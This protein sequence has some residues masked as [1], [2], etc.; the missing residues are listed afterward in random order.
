MGIASISN[1]SIEASFGLPFG[2]YSLKIKSKGNSTNLE[3]KEI[4]DKSEQILKNELDDEFVNSLTIPL[5]YQIIEFENKKLDSSIYEI[6]GKL[7][8]KSFVKTDIYNESKIYDNCYWE[9]EFLAMM[10]I[11]NI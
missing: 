8:T 7:R 2:N 11:V 4:H 5:E 9:L 10:N 6:W 1:D 3:F